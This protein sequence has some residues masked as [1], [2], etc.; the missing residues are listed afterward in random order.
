MK[1]ENEVF[2]TVGT[3]DISEG[4]D[5]IATKVKS[6]NK[7]DAFQARRVDARERGPLKERNQDPHSNYSLGYQ[8][9]SRNLSG[10]RSTTAEPHD[11]K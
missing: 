9:D 3:D 2:N 11:Q 8:D 10:L 5:T 1:D 6:K 4:P 7:L